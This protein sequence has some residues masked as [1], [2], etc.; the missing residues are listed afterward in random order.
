MI[1]RIQTVWWLV[2]AAIMG[3]CL[4]LPLFQFSELDAVRTIYARNVSFL[5]FPL[6]ALGIL[7]IAVIFLYKRRQLQ[8][9]LSYIIVVSLIAMCFGAF[10]QYQRLGTSHADIKLLPWVFILFFPVIFQILA[11]RG[12]KKDEALISSMDRLR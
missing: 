5:Y 7:T 2:A 10:V 4:F 3:A 8:V 9:T 11:I 12:V 6:V 1:Q